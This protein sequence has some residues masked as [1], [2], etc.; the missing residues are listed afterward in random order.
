[1][2]DLSSFFWGTREGEKYPLHQ[3]HGWEKGDAES[4]S[5]R[6]KVPFRFFRKERYQHPLVK[7]R[8]AFCQFGERK[9]TGS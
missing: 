9:L 7:K 4:K 8:G 5:M 3:K 6:G 1:M 2:R